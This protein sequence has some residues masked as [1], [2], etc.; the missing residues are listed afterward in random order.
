[1][2]QRSM[3][4]DGAS[5]GDA[6]TLTVNAADG[7][8]WRMSNEDYVSPFHDIMCR[9]LFNGTGNRGVLYGWLNELVPAAAAPNVTVDTGAA[10]IYGLFYRNTA[11]VSVNIPTPTNDTR[12]DYIVIRRDW[13]AQTARITRIPGSEGGGAPAIT[14]SPAPTGSGIYDIPIALVDITTGGAI[15]VTDAREFVTFCTVPIDDSITTGHIIADA[16]EWE[17]RE[18]VTKHIRF[19][20]REILPLASYFSYGQSSSLYLDGSVTATW[21]AAA[22][23]MEGWRCTGTGT[24]QDR[25]FMVAFKVPAD[26][27]PGTTIGARLWWIDDWAGATDYDLYS[28][29]Q[30]YEDGVEVALPGAQTNTDAILTSVL[31]TVHVSELRSITDLEGDEMV[32]YCVRY[33]NS[34]GAEAVLFVALEFVYTAYV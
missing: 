21:G 17:Q 32:L 9:A 5:L 13:A 7:I 11:S 23:T 10:I 15:N 16:V 3:H 6:D 20:G 28:S 12:Y 33:Y 29:Y 4:W 31:D 30:V 24:A 22:A 18:Q 26:W 34:A 2:T 8:G 1:M 14:Q 19:G 25:N 27:V